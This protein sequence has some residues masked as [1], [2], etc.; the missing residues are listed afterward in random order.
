MACT[1]EELHEAQYEMMRAFG[2]YCEKHKINYVLHG[3]TLLG[4][5]RHNYIIPWDD[6][7]DMIMDIKSFNKLVKLTK[8][9]PIEGLYFQ[10]IDRDK[11]YPINCARI[12]KNN[13]YM[14]EWRF[15]GLDMHHGV[16]IDLFVYLNKPA[17]EIGV[18][19]QEFL[20]GA[21]S[22]L[23]QRFLTD[24]KITEF[25]DTKKAQKKIQK[26]IQKTPKSLVNFFRTILF[27]IISHYG[28]KDSEFVRD[29]DYNGQHNFKEP[30]SCFEPTMLHKFG[31]T[32]LR[33]PQN[34]DKLLKIIYGDDYMTP[35]KTHTHVNL[36]SII[37]NTLG[38]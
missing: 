37:L 7:V 2:N 9:E 30:R 36:N 17:T 19:F 38:E 11:E 22:L 27:F 21:F 18:K 35:K 3:G 12:R 4:A 23:G 13:T 8:K 5:V 15:Q 31:D 32:E 10:W 16:W 26:I 25:D 29:F 33:I 34:Y 6:D 1:M 20:L 14:P 24:E 28:K